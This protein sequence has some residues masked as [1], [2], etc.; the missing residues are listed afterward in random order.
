[1]NPA[2]RVRIVTETARA[3][4]EG[5]LDAVVGAQTLA[6]Q[7]TQI[8]PHLRGDRIDVTQAEADTVALTL[9]R[10]GE[11]VSDLSPTKHDPEA[12]L[13]MARILGELAQTLR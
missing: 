12:T 11:Q 5:R 4:L 2:E 1:M 8:A 7:E 9:R 13:E 6:I 3:V 10:L